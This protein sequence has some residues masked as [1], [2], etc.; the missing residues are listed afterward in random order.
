ML[1]T[2][3]SKISDTPTDKQR[4]LLIWGHG[5]QQEPDRLPIPFT[6]EFFPYLII[7]CVLNG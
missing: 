2:P 7:E 4:L 3:C 5:L 1:Y 6:F